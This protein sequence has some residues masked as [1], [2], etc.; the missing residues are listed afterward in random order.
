[1]I[2]QLKNIKNWLQKELI[3]RGYELDIINKWLEYIE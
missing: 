2:I 3:E 1:M